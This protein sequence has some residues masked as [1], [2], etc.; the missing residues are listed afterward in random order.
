MTY[1]FLSILFSIIGILFIAFYNWE[2]FIYSLHISNKSSLEPNIIT[3]SFKTKILLFSI[4]ILSLTLG[5]LD[6]YKKRTIFGIIGIFLSILVLI[7]SFVP[8]WLIFI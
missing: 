8:I 2:M 4:G 5:L 7:F 1:S 3:T 6:F